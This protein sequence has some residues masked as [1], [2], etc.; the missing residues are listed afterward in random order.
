[1]ESDKLVQGSKN[2]VNERLFSN[3]AKQIRQGIQILESKKEFQLLVYFRERQLETYICLMNLEYQRWNYK[4]ALDC[5]NCIMEKSKHITGEFTCRVIVSVYYQLIMLRLNGR[6]C[7]LADFIHYISGELRGKTL[8]FIETIFAFRAHKLYDSAIRLEMACGSLMQK[9]FETKLS[10]AMTY[11]EQYRVEFHQRSQMR[12]EDMR[13]IHSLMESLVT[14]YPPLDG[15]ANPEYCLL[16]AQWDYLM[17]YQTIFQTKEKSI[18]MALIMIDMFLRLSLVTH[19]GG[20]K[21]AQDN[22]YTCYQAVTPSEVQLVCSGCRVACYCSIDHQ[23][24]TWKK[25]AVRGMRIGHE[26]LCPLYKSYRKYINAKNLKDEEK[27]ARMRR[28]LERE[29][30]KFLEYGLGLKNKRFFRNEVVG[31]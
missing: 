24:A 17:S 2:E 5:Y 25:E 22:C 12:K 6:E 9:P 16:L 15:N 23:R 8:A 28:R 21:V 11:F 10:L 1:M 20:S 30:V 31:E 19:E 13:R 14:E 3:A 18:E 7:Q 4:G 26:I 29:C 27:E